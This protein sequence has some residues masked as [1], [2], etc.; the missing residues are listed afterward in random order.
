MHD[1]SQRTE[2]PRPPA[3]GNGLLGKWIRILWTVIT[4]PIVLVFAIVGALFGLF[5][6]LWEGV[7]SKRGLWFTL[8]AQTLVGVL[9]GARLVFVGSSRLYKAL[10]Y[11]PVYDDDDFPLP[12][13]IDDF[14]VIGH[15]GA[16]YAAPEN[17]IAAFARAVHEGANALEIDLCYTQDGE[18]VV[19]HDWDPDAAVSLFR[20]GGLE[21]YQKYKPVYPAGDLR[22][23][24]PELT[25]AE[26]RANYGYETK[27][28]D[29]VDMTL[30]KYAIPTFREFMAWAVKQKSLKSI[31][32]DVKIP[33]DEPKWVAEMMPAIQAVLAEF[34]NSFEVVLISPWQ[35]VF[36]AMREI[37]PELPISFDREVVSALPVAT[38]DEA[39]AFSAMVEAERYA[40]R[41]ASVGRPTF[42]TLAPFEVYETII[43]HDLDYRAQKGMDVCFI[44]WTINDKAEMRDLV[45]LGVDGIL[46]DRPGRLASRVLGK[47][48]AAMLRSPRDLFKFARQGGMNPEDSSKA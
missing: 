22:R 17:T 42:L 34:D 21:D 3:R 25:L 33:S 14:L 15:R 20:E 27:G 24:T 11:R 35:E 30:P 39:R 47:K 40:N 29:P 23:P 12:E 31:F 1:V 7:T 37:A 46:T 5:V 41:F 4:Y 26:L 44:A 8:R 36:L 48:T 43:L 45:G 18:I 10:F 13:S 28:G 38:I 9:K 2:S 16:P 6:G 19:W 32:L